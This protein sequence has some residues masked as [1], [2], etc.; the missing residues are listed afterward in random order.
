MTG[1]LCLSLT[2]PMWFFARR[3]ALEA[4]S[5]GALKAGRGQPPV[6]PRAAPCATPLPAAFVAEEARWKKTL[7]LKPYTIVRGVQRCRESTRSP[8]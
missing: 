1:G 3:S 2:G 6:P 8:N 7:A 4:P 5:F